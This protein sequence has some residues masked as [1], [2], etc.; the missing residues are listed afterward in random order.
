[1]VTEPFPGRATTKLY[2]VGRQRQEK[3]PLS[4]IYPGLCP[5]RIFDFAQ[6]IGWKFR[7]QGLTVRM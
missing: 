4:Q 5:Q 7:V 3:L 6:C 2:C 1:M